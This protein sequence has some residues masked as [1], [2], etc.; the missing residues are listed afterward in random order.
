MEVI[1]NSKLFHLKHFNQ[2]HYHVGQHRNADAPLWE[3]L[4]K[5]FVLGTLE[6]RCCKT[7]LRQER[8]NEEQS[9][10]HHLEKHVCLCS[11]EETEI[12]NVLHGFLGVDTISILAVN[13]IKTLSEE[14]LCHVGS[15]IKWFFTSEV[16]SFT[17]ALF[18]RR[19]LSR[20]VIFLKD[21]TCLQV[22]QINHEMF[23]RNVE[24]FQI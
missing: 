19:F 6:F 7:H 17:K 24:R 20:V 3:T 11:I 2:E 12:K 18:H 8:K 16:L 4:V 15:I 13:I 10:K 21:S 22:T 9:V 1:R 14:L 23:D 5:G